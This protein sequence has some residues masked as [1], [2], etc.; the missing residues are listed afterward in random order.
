MLRVSFK[1]TY[2]ECVHEIQHVMSRRGGTSANEHVLA[3]QELNDTLH[4]G[5]IGALVCHAVCVMER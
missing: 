4:Q 2:P 1:T 5:A 3:R